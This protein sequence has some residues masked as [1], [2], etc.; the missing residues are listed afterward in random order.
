MFRGNRLL[1]E[2]LT[3]GELAAELLRAWNV[4]YVFGLGGS[5]EVGFLDAIVDRIELQYVHG[6]HEAVVVG[7]ADGYARASRSSPFVNLHAV[8]GAGYALASMANAFKDHTSIVVTAGRQATKIRGTNAFLE[9]VNLHELPREYVQWSWDVTAASTIPEVLRR[10]FIMAEMPPGGPTFVTVSKDLWE[11][12]VPRAEIVPRARSQIVVDVRPSDEHVCMLVDMLVEAELPVVAVGK[13][14]VWSDPSEDLMELS[15]LVGIAVFQDVYWSHTPMIF[16]ST[17]PHYLGMYH[18]DPDFTES[19]D[20]FWAL[21]GT[22]FSLMEL[23]S[24]PILPRACTVIHTGLD[25]AEL[26]RTY[27]VDLAIVAG[28]QPTVSAVLEELKRRKL[29]GLAVDDRR[30]RIEAYHRQRRARLDERAKSVWN[31]SPVTNERLMVELNRGIARDA[32]IVSEVITSEPY[33]SAY[34]DIDHSS[35]DRR[36]NLATSGGVLGWGV[37]AAVGARIG[38]PH[39]EVWALVGDGAFQFGF[40]ALW[41]AARYEVPVGVVIWNNGEFQANRSFLHAYGGRAAATGRYVGCNLGFPAID[42]VSL[43]KGYGVEGERVH[44]PSELASAIERCQRAMREGRPYVLDVKVERRFGGADSE[45][46]DAFSV[47][48]R[49]PRKS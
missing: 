23:P 6:L 37:P 40:Q 30:R 1:F 3:G 26:G 14:A 46:F 10:A 48:K 2:N 27:P 20:L 9:S 17:H 16:P 31:D 21:G 18:D 44:E 36:R 49:L 15:E 12:R 11:E 42:A 39:R 7:M 4:P 29:D 47:A 43:A 38:E 32:I 25:R 5:E 22:M 35:P 24:E 41:T 45:W 33:V 28:V 13:E 34:I 19:P 8:A